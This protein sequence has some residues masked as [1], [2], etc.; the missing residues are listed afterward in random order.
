MLGGASSIT[1]FHVRGIRISVDWS[2]FIVLFL[3]IVW[4]SGFYRDILGNPDDDFGPYALAV[5]SA[6]GFFG[7][8]LLHELGHAVVAIRRGIGIS[9]IQLWIFG[10]VARMDRESD[11]PKTEYQVAIAG[12]LVTLAIVV[13]LV[14]VT[15]VAVGISG[16]GDALL[17]RTGAT[18]SGVLAMIAWLATINFLVLVFNLLPAFPMDGGRIVRAI[19]WKRSGD[20]NKATRFAAKLGQGFGFLFIG[21]GLLLIL[22]GLLITGVW[23]ALVGLIINGSAKAA[24]AQ[25]QITGRLAGMTVADVMDSEPV[26]IPGD[27]S[28]DRAL[29]EYFLRYQWPWFPVVDPARRFL[30]LL[31]RERA[32]EVPEPQR[33][34]SEVADLLGD[35]GIGSF[36]VTIDTPLE[37]LL[38]SGELRRRGAL[39]AVDAHGKLRG[40]ITTDQVGRA[41]RNAG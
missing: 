13:A 16:L 10:G 9:G 34:A 40:V 24:S 1:L 32:D 17:I 8:I 3:V 14:L 20:R 18:N 35:E 38:G 29:E 12:P 33:A 25:T 19:A 41:L 7:S 11:S 21:G 4:M 5:L 2:W 31:D 27:V 30:G 23:L 39:I 28:V 37:S 22:S 26:A 15:T 6:L 36:S